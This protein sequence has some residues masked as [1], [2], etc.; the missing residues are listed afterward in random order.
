MWLPPWHPAHAQR[1]ATPTL[2][3]PDWSSPTIGGDALPGND[4]YVDITPV[5]G[6]THYE[7]C[8]RDIGAGGC[9]FQR[10]VRAEET[11]YGPGVTARARIVVDLPAHKQGTIGEWTAQ[12]CA[13]ATCSSASSSGFAPFK[14]F[15]ILT[16]PAQVTAFSGTQ[17]SRT[18]TFRW[19]NNPI[20][21]AGTQLVILSDRASAV[22]F[23]PEDPTT[24]APPS[25]S[26]AVPVGANS[27]T[28]T[29]PPSFP[30]LARWAVATCREFQGKGRR[31]SLLTA[32][33][34][35]TVPPPPTFAT[36][37]LPTFRH[38]RCIN[39]HAVAADNFQKAT[40]ANPNRGLPS[41]HP[42]VTAASDCRSCHTNAL[43]P[44]EGTLNPGWQAAPADMDFRNKSDMHLCLAANLPG[45]KARDVREHLTQD[46]LIL[47]AVGDGRRPADASGSALP[48]LPVAPP[49]SIAQWRTLVQQW[50]D[51]G[52]RCN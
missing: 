7:V 52:M 11:A 1:P 45:S 3:Y 27:H 37:L 29:L 23:R 6:A 47:W 31:C 13:S 9:W 10:I 14:R 26:I 49:M 25:M 51:G 44:S 17:P 16:H 8:L 2:V 12:A 21:T 15:L 35:V 20:A 43:L 18:V 38:A 24:V 28:V 32:W 34:M 48:A 19:T 41:T 39:C 36:T 4:A 5:P 33:A 42:D 46:K 40:A 22:G 30:N 50:L